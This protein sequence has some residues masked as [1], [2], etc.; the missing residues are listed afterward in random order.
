MRPLSLAAAGLVALWLLAR[1]RR[2]RLTHLGAAL[3]AL[4]VG[5]LAVHG[6]GAFAL[7]SLE[8]A[9]R[10]AG[11]ALGP[12]VYVLAAVMAFLET[13]AFVGLLV[14]GETVIL[15]AGTVAGAGRISIVWLIALVWASAVAGDV[16]SLVLG[17]RLGRRFVL[18]HGWRVQITRERFE[19][20]ERFYRRHG[21]KA[22]LLGRFVGVVR[23]ISPFVAGSSGMP[24]RRFLPF[25]VAGAGL[26]GAGIALLGYF[27]W[28]SFDHA[29]E[30]AGRGALAVGAVIVAGV[31][32]VAGVR[33]LRERRS[34]SP[35]AG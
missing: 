34:G 27:L 31:A 13:A 18:R 7:P 28:E 17:R 33:R 21:G 22:V 26:W 24:L 6:A 8:H 4:A 14:P 32:V 10:S 19:R 23:A 16:T 9:A 1:V 11:E 20:V 12:Y 3:G 25:D 15:L 5:A 29:S 30:V 2:G 35:A